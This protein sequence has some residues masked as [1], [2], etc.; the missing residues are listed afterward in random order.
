MIAPAIARGT[1]WR[2]EGFGD[3]DVVFEV[4][5]DNGLIH[6]HATVVGRE[7]D[8]VTFTFPWPQAAEMM[9]LRLLREAYRGGED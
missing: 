1:L 8:V 7:N 2:D 4:E 6:L 3:E 9:A 5:A